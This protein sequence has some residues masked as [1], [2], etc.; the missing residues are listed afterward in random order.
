[1]PGAGAIAE[2]RERLQAVR[3][4]IPEIESQKLLTW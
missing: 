4:L 1:M 3:V 2:F